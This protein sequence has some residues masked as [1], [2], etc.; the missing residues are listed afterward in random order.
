MKKLLALAFIMLISANIMAQEKSITFSSLAG[1]NINGNTLNQQSMNI[2]MDL[3][4]RTSIESWSGF[5]VRQE[6]NSWFTTTTTINRSYNNFKIGAG[7]MFM[8]GDQ[9]GFIN[10]NV[11][12]END[13]YFVAKLTYKIKF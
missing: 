10:N 4:K 6:L 3:T 2:Y 12:F 7:A 9:N 5:G 11:S 8:S 1:V 13:F